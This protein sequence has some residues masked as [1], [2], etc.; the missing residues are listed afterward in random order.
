MRPQLKVIFNTIIFFIQN[1]ARDSERQMI[2]FGVFGTIAYPLF[3]ILNLHVLEPK[4]YE[5]LYLRLSAGGLCLG[6][7]FKNYWPARFRKFLPFYWYLTLLYGLPFFFTFMTLKN[8]ASN[9]WLLNLLTVLFVAMLMI[10]WIS[11]VIL[12]ITGC[13]LGWLAYVATDHTH[14][15]YIEKTISRKD[16]I[17]AY[18]VTVIFGILFSRN[19]SLSEKDKIQT[20]KSLAANIAH[21]LRTPLA[22]IQAGVKGI[23]KYYGKLLE[24]YELAKQHD[25]PV[26]YIGQEHLELLRTGL[27]SVE[28]EVNHTSIVLEMLLTNIKQSELKTQFTENFSIMECVNYALSYYP[29]T[30]NHRKQIVWNPNESSDFV[31]RGNKMLFIHVLFNLL[32]NALYFVAKAEKGQ[33]FIWTEKTLDRQI[34]HFK[35]TG[36]GIPKKYLPYIFDRFFTKDTHQGTGIGLSFCKMIMEGMGGQITCDSVEGE[37]THFQLSFPKIDYNHK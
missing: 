34:L 20:M 32:R 22:A 36:T 12:F 3:S 35:D 31:V 11:V 18:I 5:N 25:L 2:I 26:K 24:G 23:S 13:L 27:S 1:Q 30:D 37:Y 17:G 10:D 9:E 16:L 15:I 28:N 29:M 19:K 6:L 7:A 8:H 14:F 33:I 4:I 21:E